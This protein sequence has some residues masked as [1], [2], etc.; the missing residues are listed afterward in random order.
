MIISQRG[1]TRAIAAVATVLSC[2]TGLPPKAAL[3]QNPRDAARRYREAHEAEILREFSDLLAIPNVAADSVNIRRNAAALTQMLGRRGV[4]ARLLEV[5]GASPAV[6]GELRA[7]GASRTLVLYAHY[8]GQPVDPRQWRGSAWQPVLRSGPLSPDVHEVPWPAAGA[9]TDPNT[10]VFARSAS[11]DKGTIIAMLAALDAMRDAGIRPSV[12]LKFFFEG[13]E[14]AGSPHLQAILERYRQELRADAWA[15]CDGPS[16]QSGR[17]QVVFGMRG[18]TGLELTVYG[19]TRALHSGHYG[20]WAP[21]PAISLAR[22]I[23]S[24]RDDDGRITIVGFYDDV[25]PI[26]DAE[27]RAIAALPS[28]D[29]TL[30]ASLGLARSEASNALLAERIMLPALN[31]RGLR[32]GNVQELAANAIPIEAD[33]SI[34]FRL[35]PNQR[36]EHVRELVEAHVRAQGWQIVG[37]VPDSA[38]RLRFP[39]IVRL[40]WESGYPASRAAMD[41]PFAKAFVRAAGDG[42]AVPPLAVPTLGGSGPTYLFEQVLGVPAVVLPIANYDNNQHA[43]NENLRV[44]HL[45]DGIE[46]YAALLAKLGKE[47]GPVP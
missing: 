15:F 14:E 47:W 40:R 4:T 23:T 17:Q 21:N 35:V 34:D 46:M 9:R 27:R 8:D 24:M 37:E 41:S 43:A 39:K 5:A 1:W 26:S 16:H 20:N 30:R 25:R 6:F 18:V 12:N 42:A 31:V 38:T 2:A 32:A 22:L 3:G 13:E 7:P 44:G 19:P 33:A 11:D 29:P 10:R 28:V 45:W 36:P